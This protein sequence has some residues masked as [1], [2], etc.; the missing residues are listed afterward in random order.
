M[1]IE[2]NAGEIRA[3]LRLVE[4][5]AAPEPSAE[6]ARAS[7][8]DRKG[9]PPLVVER[10]D[11]LVA[12]GRRPPVATIERGACSGCHLRLPTMVESKVTH[13]L[14]LHTCPHCRRMLY[15]RELLE[16][17]PVGPSRPSRRKQRAP[18]EDRPS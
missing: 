18:A 9:L 1:T 13:A 17:T 7:N 12:A 2:A 6:S 5:D 15:S 3:L 4:R 10:Y 16:S 8:A 11:A 14:A